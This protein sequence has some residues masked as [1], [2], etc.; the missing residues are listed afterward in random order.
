MFLKLPQHTCVLICRGR[1][2]GG[3]L[4]NGKPLAVPGGLRCDAGWSADNSYGRRS[5]QTFWTE[6][7]DYFLKF[8]KD[9]DVAFLIC[10]FFFLFV[11]IATCTISHQLHG[12]D[13]WH[14]PSEYKLKHQKSRSFPTRVSLWQLVLFSFETFGNNNIFTPFSGSNKY[15]WIIPIL[16]S[17]LA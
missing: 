17:A 7:A 3:A 9:S 4:Q 10:L 11:C 13:F 12:M 6:Y 5:N 16:E 1:S 15:C 2:G 14:E 8:T